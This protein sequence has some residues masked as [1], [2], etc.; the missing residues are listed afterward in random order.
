MILR[1]Q[2]FF[3]FLFYLQLS[4]LPPPVPIPF[5]LTFSV[6]ARLSDFLNIKVCASVALILNIK[7]D[8]QALRDAN[9][10]KKDYTYR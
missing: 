9:A 2:T 3:L 7:M 4:G 8:S 10:A 5:D 6:Y 1:G